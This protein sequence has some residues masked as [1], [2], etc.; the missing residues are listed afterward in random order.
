[1][2]MKQ[3]TSEDRCSNH[4]PYIL[5]PHFRYNLMEKEMCMQ[6]AFMRRTIDLAIE[7]VH[8]GHGGPFAALVV[9][10]GK[11]VATGSNLVTFS[12]DPTAHAEMN[13]IREACH[14]LG[15]FKLDGCDIYTISEPCPM[16]LGAIYWARLDRVYFANTAEDAASV[17]FD[18]SAIFK[19]LVRPM[20]ERRIP[21]EQIMRD[22]AL[23]AFRVWEQKPDKIQY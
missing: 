22:Q 21:F 5:Q 10:E 12:N 6:N 8:S 20:A 16:C 19:E 9:R 23:E 18:D 2:E 1:M 4:A 11:V 15:S 13:A 14:A 7:N 17:G 3:S